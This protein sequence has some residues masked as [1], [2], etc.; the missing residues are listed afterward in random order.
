MIC[1]NAWKRRWDSDTTIIPFSGELSNLLNPK[2]KRIWTVWE[3]TMGSRVGEQ[4]AWKMDIQTKP[5]NSGLYHSLFQSSATLFWTAINDRHICPTAIQ[6]YNLSFLQVRKGRCLLSCH[7]TWYAENNRWNINYMCD[8][9][10]R[11]T[12]PDSIGLL[13]RS[14]DLGPR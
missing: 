2:V 13:A 9:E 7:I 5:Q 14:M 10:R 6:A 3:L 11:P 12:D 1:F 8:R 4:F